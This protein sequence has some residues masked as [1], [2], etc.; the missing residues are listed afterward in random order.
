MATVL[1]WGAFNVNCSYADTDYGSDLPFGLDEEKFIPQFHQEGNYTYY[2]L[3][4]AKKEISISKVANVKNQL[5]IPTEIDGY[6]VTGLGMLYDTFYIYEEEGY[7]VD[8][9]RIVAK[10]DMYKVKS[11]T[12]PEGVKYIGTNSFY[13]MLKVK[14]ISFPNSL[15]SIQS[16]A[17]VSIDAEE[18]VLP[19]NLKY[20]SNY[21]FR[22]CSSLKRVVIKSKV[23]SFGDEYPAFR[24]C[25]ALKE[26][27]LDGVEKINMDGFRLAE[28]SDKL[29]I[30]ASV[31]EIVMLTC[32]FKQVI[33]KGTKTEFYWYDGY[34]YNWNKTVEIYVPKNAEAIHTLKKLKI[35]YKEVTLPSAP[36]V[37]KKTVSSGS[38]SKVLLSWNSQRGVTAYEIY[39]SKE[40]NGTYKR[41]KV[42]G[43]THCYTVKQPGYIAV[44]AYKTLQKEKWYSEFTTIKL[45]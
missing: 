34:N 24:C 14:D 29:V 9:Y 41:L 13:G 19:A 33:V 27:V 28:N 1:F 30:S 18:I 7:S 10:E 36:K 2:I 12:I 39:Y 45:P 23:L 22:D 20:I 16:D 11:I 8:E 5:V 38:S 31:K 32:N 44:R 40:K 25:D 15:Q 3:D 6:K 37:T 43:K 21:S 35:K 4:E 42:T 17:F 26:V